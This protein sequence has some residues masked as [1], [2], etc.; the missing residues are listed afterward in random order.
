LPWYR[1]FAAFAHSSLYMSIRLAFMLIVVSITDWA[2]AHIAFFWLIA[3]ALC[4]SPFVF[5]PHQ[6]SLSTLLTDYGEA[7]RWFWREEFTT[8]NENEK[9]AKPS[10]SWI[11]MV[12]QQRRRITGAVGVRQA[13]RAHASVVFAHHVA[14]PILTSFV[15]SF[16]YAFF[17]TASA[18]NLPSTKRPKHVPLTTHLVAVG[19]FAV[20]PIAVHAALVTA[21]LVVSIVFGTFLQCSSTAST[22]FGQLVAFIGR[23]VSLMLFGGLLIGMWMFEHWS[24]G[25]LILSTA[26]FSVQRAVV[27]SLVFLLS[28][29]RDG[30]SVHS[31]WWSGKW[32][33]RKLGYRVFTQIFRYDSLI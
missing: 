26:V 6:F 4:L 22:S 20:G 9:M 29:E 14:L 18:A 33:G 8:P 16:G 2:P 7:V 13:N 12:H 15:F 30:K 25:V 21:L 27:S 10:N 17:K 31:A 5:N 3:I 19:L 24:P 28:R 1:L 23:I 11:D 32:T